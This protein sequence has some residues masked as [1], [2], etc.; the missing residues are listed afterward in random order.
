MAKLIYEHDNGHQVTFEIA[1]NI[2]ET[3]NSEL[4]IVVWDEFMKVLKTEILAQP[5]GDTV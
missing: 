5:Q 2:A 3:L 4:G 1:T